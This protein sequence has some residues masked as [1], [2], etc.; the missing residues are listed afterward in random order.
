MLGHNTSL[1]KFKKTDIVASIFSDHNAM[2]L[3]CNH[4]KKTAN[5]TK[6]WK[7]TDM[8]LNNE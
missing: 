1:D 4:M 5:N 8:L 2:K 3:E 6:T 7:L